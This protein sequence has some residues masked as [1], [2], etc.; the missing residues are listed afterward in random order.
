MQQRIP[1]NVDPGRPAAQ[2]FVVDLAAQGVAGVGDPFRAQGLGAGQRRVR[3]EPDGMEKLRPDVEI[4]LAKSR[5]LQSGRLA[6]ADQQRHGDAQADLHLASVGRDGKQ[7]DH[8]PVLAGGGDQHR[9]LAAADHIFV[10]LPGPGAGTEGRLALLAIDPQRQA[11]YHGARWQRDLRP[12][13]LLPRRIVLQDHRPFQIGQA[14]LGIDRSVD[15]RSRQTDAGQAATHDAAADVAVETLLPVAQTPD[16]RFRQV[17]EGLAGDLVIDLSRL[18][19]VDRIAE[20]E[21]QADRVGGQA[22]ARIAQ[23]PQHF[24]V[25]DRAQPAQASL[26]GFR[27]GTGRHL[28]PEARQGE[29]Q[30]DDDQGQHG[31]DP[32]PPRR[33]QPGAAL[34]GQATLEQHASPPGRQQRQQRRQRQQADAEVQDHERGEGRQRQIEQR[35]ESGDAHCD[36][37]QPGQRCAGARTR[38]CQLDQH[39][40]IG[41]RH[42]RNQQAMR[43]AR[44]RVEERLGAGLGIGLKSEGEG[45]QDDAREQDE[46]SGREVRIARG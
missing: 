41:Q 39:P 32:S 26:S 20:D 42:Q 23:M 12:A 36:R 2:F 46:P 9:V 31:Q 35:V 45:R 1:G 25:P 27:L 37:L 8:H 21:Q 5:Q 17:V 28:H 10:G 40:G 29:R 18:D 34:I 11:R 4:A 7:L 3:F 24:F 13:F 44:N 14:G 30:V 22:G 16:G 43:K 15:A 33:R 38:L 6:I 19:Q